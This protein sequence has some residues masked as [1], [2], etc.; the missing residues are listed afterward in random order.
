[1]SLGQLVLELKLNGNEFTVGLKSAEGALAQFIAGTNRANVAVKR[2]EASHRSWGKT[3]RDSIIGLALVRDAVRTLSDVTFGWQR[4]IIATNSEMEKS[5]MLMKN[6]SKQ[7]DPMVATQEAVADV[8]NLLQRASTSPF[9]LTQ[10]TDAFVKLRV[11][12]VEPVWKSLD[13]LIDSV[14][15]FGGSGEQLKRAGVAI[16]QMA[17]K[18]VISMEELRQQLGEAVPTAIN[19]MA[20]ALGTSYS[21][22]VKEISQG[23]VT[24]KPAILAM[25]Q[26]LERSFAGSAAAMMNT[27]GGAVAQFETGVKKLAVAFGG[28][29]EG[30]YTEGGYLKTVTNE[31][32]GLTEVLNSPDMISSARELGKSLAELVTTVAN[33]TKWI[34][35]HREA[36]Y[37]W[38]KALLYLWAAF[39]GASIISGVLGTAGTAMQALSMRM[40]QMR[41]QGQGVIS[42]MTSFAGA[43]TGWNSAA[44]VAAGGA[45]RIATGSAAAGTAVRLL[46]GALGIIAG[47]IGMVAGLAIAG[48]A[49]WYEY[50]KGVNEAE[51]AILGLQGALT[52]M[53]QL[54][55]LG[56]VK[57][58]MQ[59]DFDDEFVNDNKATRV[60]RYG[61][62]TEFKAAR[63]KAEDELMQVNAD[64]LKARGNVAETQANAEAQREI[65]SNQAALGEISRKYVIDKE[66]IR[67][68]MEDE[69]KT[70]GK[71]LD[72]D[73][74]AEAFIKE[75]KTRVEAEISLYEK[76]LKVQEDK[77][78]ELNANNG[79]SGT[80]A[81][82]DITRITQI[83]AG[84][85]V[86]DDYR[87]KISEA[88]DAL[89]TLG[90]VKLADTIVGGD[91][92]GGGKPQF[93]ALKIFVDGLSKSVATLGAKAEE[94]NP[95]MAQLDATVE[96]LGGKKL[97]NFDEIYAQGVRL[98]EQKWAQEKANKAVSASNGI[99]ADTMERISQIT[100]L[101]S[102]K[103]NKAEETN[104]WMKASADALR[105]ED[106]LRELIKVAEEARQKAI[107]AQ[108]GTL[109][110]G[111][112][113]DLKAKAMLAE[114]AVDEATEAI[115][116][117]KVAA[118]GKQMGEDAFDITASLK[119]QTEQT[120]MEYERKVA[121]AEDFFRR[122]KQYLDEDASAYANYQAY[123]IALDDQFA[124]ENESGL[125]AWIRANKDATEQ[126]KS[127][128]GS[129]MDKF[130][131]TIVDGLASGKFEFGAFVEY[132]LKEFLRIQIAKQMAMAAEAV[133]G[134]SGFLG[135]IASGV[136]SYFGGG[137]A[138]GFAAGSAGATSSSLGASSAGYSKAYG[139]ANGGIMTDQGAVALRKYAKGGIADRPQLALYGEGSM[140]EA[141]VP[142]PDGRSI[143][144]TMTGAAQAGAGN[145]ATGPVPVQV[146]LYNQAG[147]KQEATSSSKFDGEQMVVDIIL[148]KVSQPGPVRDA[149]RTAAA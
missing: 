89:L 112:L 72:E 26:E 36:I 101:M 32:K 121:Q 58:R 120:R 113:D 139:F 107:A 24:S 22:L 124:R 63:K 137:G 83:K 110:E 119:T 133:S 51:K 79:K 97:K 1:M 129:A 29:E 61:G 95:Y 25:M 65:Q 46:G 134:S 15:A 31:L 130:N 66:A 55:T 81:D 98:A 23:K 86:M 27:W 30:G 48:G 42:T 43:A 19:A 111:L 57:S 21:K 69:A 132:L 142:L 109:G 93:D 12:G 49:A 76:A 13:T 92:G 96:S 41:M 10:V 44:A 78:A 82:T 91:G 62:I 104:P 35:E 102:N 90:K 60:Y 106:E 138:N 74:L 118:A 45:T 128:W 56:G 77:Q 17:G 147:E 71:K 8:N 88:K 85:K 59:E 37:E 143:P 105:Y 114:K 100:K 3:I 39:K 6:F 141:F 148:K 99:Y 4:A 149:V 67:K 84:T 127:L 145:Q 75:Q 47:P 73:K 68:K 80:E 144:V 54:K 115:N 131:D 38:G 64:M 7:K 116:R 5:I 50:K 125:A 28:L 103:G 146:N 16:Q 87:L 34:I 2:A 52:S 117:T 53:S 94:A 20:D 33:G 123:R 126:Y 14:A 136:G 9:N 70:S 11:G 18:G 40:I 135:A 140:N 122:N 108:N